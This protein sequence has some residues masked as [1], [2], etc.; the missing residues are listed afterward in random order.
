MADLRPFAALRPRADAAAEVACPPYDVVTRQ[1]ALDVLAR[2]PHSFMRVARPDV[3]L[4]AELDRFD[5]R[6]DQAGQRNLQ[7]LIEEGWLIKEAAPAFY[8]YE[9]T[10][11]HHV[12]IG[13][14]AAGSLDEYENNQIKRHEKTRALELEGRTRH[15]EALQVNS[16]PIFITYRAQPA[17]DALVARLREGAPVYDY[18]LDD[19]VRHRFWVVADPAAVAGLQRAFDAVPACY[20]ADG[21]H[22]TAA[23][24]AVRQRRLAQ[25][26]ASGPQGGDFFMGLFFPHDQMQILP[27]NRVVTDR[28]GRT[29][30]ALVAAIAAAGFE[31]APAATPLP[32]RATTFGMYC[33][34]AWYRLRARPGSFPTDD[35]VRRLDVSILQDNLLAPILGISEPRTDARLQFVG[36]IR[37]SAELVRRADKNGG[38]AFTV[39]PVAIDEVMAVADA[40]E[41]MP[42]KSTWFE[43]KP[44][45]GMAVRSLVDALPDRIA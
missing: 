39:F 13:V 14:V 40:G 22:R 8:L 2:N 1:E 12:Q 28:G 23:A 9:L 3:E 37:G 34:G 35:V 15:I 20:I 19:G 10:F 38:V 41:V 29:A 31:V 4:P 16:G 17:I 5:P 43:P 33:D 11:G 21:H 25:G 44:R 6:I 42:P 30:A 36:G 24:A 18:V 26:K 27:Y 32:E 7:A 45:S